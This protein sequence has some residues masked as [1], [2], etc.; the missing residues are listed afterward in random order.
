MEMYLISV[1][2]LLLLSNDYGDRFLSIR[3][4]VF[5]KL[6]APSNQLSSA[7]R[8]QDSPKASSVNNFS[9]CTNASI[10]RIL[11]EKAYL[12]VKEK[13][14][15][16]VRNSRSHK[17]YLPGR[18]ALK[19]HGTH[20]RRS[21]T[22]AKKKHRWK[23]SSKKLRNHSKAD[24]DAVGSKSRGSSVL[25][26]LQDKYEEM[27]SDDSMVQDIDE[28]HGLSSISDAFNVYHIDSNIKQQ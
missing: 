3:S 26:K 25:Q 7:S 23:G 22:R 24:D 14:K 1:V 15:R 19:K 18:K 6:I 8:L 16:F 4:L 17:P 21:R 27:G 11:Q 28:S 5:G 12:D 10:A 2:L 13:R 9:A 20:N